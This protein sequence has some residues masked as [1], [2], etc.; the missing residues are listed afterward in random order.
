MDQVKDVILAIA[1]LLAVATHAKADEKP[2]NPAEVKLI[3]CWAE[4]RAT[5][6]RF[7]IQEK[8]ALVRECLAR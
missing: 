5:G 2:Q 1:L 4:A 6:E 7:T 8:E 3:S